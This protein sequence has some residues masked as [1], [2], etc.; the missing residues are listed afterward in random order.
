MIAWAIQRWKKECPWFRV[1]ILAHRKELIDQ[2][3]K[4]L[5]GFCPDLDIGVYS[6]SLKRRDKD[7]SVLF[8]SI[9][10][11]FKRSD[12]FDPWDVIMVD[13]AHRIP[14]SGEGK[15]RRFINGSLELNKDLRVIGWTATPFRMHGGP[16]CHKD[17]ILNEVCYE[18]NVSDL[19]DDGYLTRLR[20]KV[21]V[22]QPKLENVRRNTGGDYIGKA[23]SNAVVTDSL[24]GRAVKEVVGIIQAEDR[25]SVVF[26]C[27]DV[28]HCGLISEELKKHGIDAPAV[29]A[30]TDPDVRDK[31]VEDFRSGAIDGVCNVNVY[32]EGFNARNIDC[33]VL[34]RPTMSAGLYAQMVGR[35]LRTFEGKKDCLVLDFA[36]CIDEHG[37]IDTLGG[38]FTAMATCSVCRESFSR[39]IRV[40]PKCGWSIPKREVDRLDKVDADRRMHGE[41][42][43]EKAILSG[44]AVVRLVDDVFVSRHK[45]PGSP[46]SLKIQYRC[47]I[48]MYPEWICLEHTGSVGARAQAWLNERSRT[49]GR[50]VSVN[51]ALCIPELATVIELYTRTITI[52]RK[53]KY[54]SVINY[55]QP[56]NRN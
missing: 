35:G 51:V 17:H 42:A 18:A 54:T 31:I 25:E 3:M 2:N 45:K 20:S 55:N 13:E 26:F 36:S 10:S 11:V 48:D 14:M 5:Q 37:P 50:R 56:V 4:E 16:I 53:G 19:I 8:A 12:E 44:E 46:D 6:A 29:T 38:E 49:G 41:K 39:A 9:D 43:A 24:I 21:G 7:C 40:C 47:G 33:I 34:L 22:V 27:V 23:L 28:E 32:T 15:Y 1:V 52:R 30:D